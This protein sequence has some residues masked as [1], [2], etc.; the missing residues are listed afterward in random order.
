MAKF[1]NFGVADFVITL[2]SIGTLTLG[3]F[4]AFNVLLDEFCDLEN[5]CE[6][7]AFFSNFFQIFETYLHFG[8]VHGFVTDIVSVTLHGCVVLNGEEESTGDILKFLVRFEG[9]T[10]NFIIFP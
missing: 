2:I 3:N 1:L 10:L 6:I 9:Y 8:Q 7:L 4:A 5:F